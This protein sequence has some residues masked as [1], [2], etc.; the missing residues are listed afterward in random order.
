M[1]NASCLTVYCP[2][3]KSLLLC[4]LSE[5]IVAPHW[6]GTGVGGLGRGLTQVGIAG[7]GVYPCAALVPNPGCLIPR[8]ADE[9]SSHGPH[10]SVGER[11]TPS[12]YLCVFVGPGGLCVPGALGPGGEAGVA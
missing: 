4:S 7:L 2:K 11:E 1:L 8:R 12:W 6:V 5:T 10:C 3:K 9:D